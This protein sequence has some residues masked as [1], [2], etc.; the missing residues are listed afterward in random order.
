MKKKVHFKSYADYPKSVS[1]NAKTGI[2]LNQRH[3]NKC[4]TQ[5]GKVRAQQLANREPISE[6]TIR[7]MYSYLSRAETYYDPSKTTGCGTI[8][9]LLWGG[10]SGLRWSRSKLK[11]LGHDLAKIGPRGGINPSRKAPKSKTP[12]DGKKGS[13]RNKPGAA[14][15]PSGVKVPES[16]M[17][18]LQRKADA[19]NEKFKKKRGYGTTVGQLKTV[20]QRG[21]GAFQTSHSP[22][23]TSAEQWG[24]AR[25]NAYLYL[26]KNG[27]PQNP[28]YVGDYDLLPKGHPKSKKK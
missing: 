3:N 11:E 22:N 1:N 8:S 15:K 17:K 6:Q 28:K 21:V 25:V 4:A 12:G 18:S 16:V 20:Y 2:L 19:W 23:V 26:L 24:Q 14:K 5:V 9:F 13:I 27:R 10:K 7:R